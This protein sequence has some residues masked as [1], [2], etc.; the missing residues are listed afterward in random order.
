MSPTETPSLLSDPSATARLTTAGR[1]LV[2]AGYAPDP[3]SVDVEPGHCACG[4]VLPDPDALCCCACGCAGCGK[5]GA[6]L[7][8]VPGREVWHPE[9]AATAGGAAQQAVQAMAVV[10]LALRIGPVAAVRRA[11]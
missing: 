1:R 9:C 4:G 6:S 5:P 3:A 7:V 11:S 10:R 8:V 2:D